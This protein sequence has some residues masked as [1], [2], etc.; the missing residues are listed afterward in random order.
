M[1]LPGAGL[2][3]RRT[4][5]LRPGFGTVP[6]LG[7]KSQVGGDLSS[8]VSSRHG[9]G[10][11]R[12]REN[13]GSGAQTIGGKLLKRGRGSILV[14]GST[15]PSIMAAVRREI[16]MG[17]SMTATDGDSSLGEFPEDEGEGDDGGDG[18]GDE[19][20]GTHAFRD[21]DAASRGS[22]ALGESQGQSRNR[23]SGTGGSMPEYSDTE[24]G[25]DSET[26]RTEQ[27]Q[28]QGKGQ[29][30]VEGSK[31]RGKGESTHINDATIDEVGDGDE[32]DD[33]EAS[34][35]ASSSSTNGDNGS[36]GSD[37]SEHRSDKLDSDEEADSDG[38]SGAPLQASDPHGKSLR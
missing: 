28:E 24:S 2:A 30:Q 29:G 5:L 35:S 20:V 38:H 23:R 15:A 31:G 32:D 22:G 11:S 16:R 10:K 12:A 17:R 25:S 26:D 36:T 18:N 9:R 21:S 27:E 14:T 34:S 1:T 13:S 3:R 4:M 8:D 19:A 7:P 6:A 33:E 37:E